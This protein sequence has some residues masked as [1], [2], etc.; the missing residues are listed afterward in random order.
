MA[1]LVQSGKYGSVNTTDKATN[2][3]YVIILSSESYALQ[4]NTTIDGKIIDSGELV[5][6]AQYLCSMQESTDY[7]WGQHPQ[8]Q[9]MTVPTRTIL[10]TR[11]NVTTITD[12]RDIPKSVCNR[13]QKQNHIKTSY[14]SDLF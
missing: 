13:T 14:M 9:V 2:C 10:H 4:D 1:L 5:I 12:I 6:K 7:F 3:F 8:Q 11:L